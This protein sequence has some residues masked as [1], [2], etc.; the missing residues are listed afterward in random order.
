MQKKILKKNGG[1]LSQ[2]KTLN[3]LPL[4]MFPQLNDIL[5]V[6]KMS[7]ETEFNQNLTAKNDLLGRNCEIIKLSRTRTERAG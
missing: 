6:A 2:L 5:L 3:L 4:P 1:N 7:T